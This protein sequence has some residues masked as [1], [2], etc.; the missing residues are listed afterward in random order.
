MQA[1]TATG[2]ATTLLRS[3]LRFDATATACQG[4]LSRGRKGRRGIQWLQVYQA[5]QALHRARPA[6]HRA[7]QAL[8]QARQALSGGCTCGSHRNCRRSRLLAARG[9]QPGARRR[10]DLNLNSVELDE[11]QRR[12]PRVTDRLAVEGWTLAA[13]GRQQL[14]VPGPVEHLLIIPPLQR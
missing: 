6:L 11:P 1:F 8:H 12:R 14:P 4:L 9:R 2:R 7:R 13:A 10:L 5:R 3:S